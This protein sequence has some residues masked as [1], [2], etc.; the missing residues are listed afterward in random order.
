[1]ENEKAKG[2]ECNNSEKKKENKIHPMV[3][4]SSTKWKGMNFRTLRISSICNSL[5]CEEF[6]AN[7]AFGCK[8]RKKRREI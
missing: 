3:K 6:Y 8:L 4:K 1:M 7:E 2:N 5:F